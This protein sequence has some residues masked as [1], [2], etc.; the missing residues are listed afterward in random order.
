MFV[1]LNST[2]LDYYVDEYGLPYIAQ[3]LN[4]EAIGFLFATPGG[5]G[6]IG[7]KRVESIEQMHTIATIKP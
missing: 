7:M 6:V 2:L 3:N 5:Y 1:A 4:G